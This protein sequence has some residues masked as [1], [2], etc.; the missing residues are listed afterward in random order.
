MSPSGG[1][2]KLLTNAW[3][4]EGPSWSPN[5]RV[6]N[7]V[8]T[9]APG[10]STNV[11]VTLTFACANQ[12]GAFGQTYTIVAVADDNADDGGACPPFALQSFACTTAVGND[13]Q[14]TDYVKSRTCCEVHHP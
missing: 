6:I 8:V 10:Q 4:D 2:E 12:N 3:Q 7:T 13:D 14:D 5:G 11:G 9:L 1:G